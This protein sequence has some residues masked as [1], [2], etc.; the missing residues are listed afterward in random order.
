MFVRKLKGKRQLEKHRCE[1]KDN[2]RPV[3]REV[4]WKAWNGCIWLRIGINGGIL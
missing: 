2:I 3:I 1:W 4:G